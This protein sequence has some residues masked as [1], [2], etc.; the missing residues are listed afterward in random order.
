MPEVLDT[1]VLAAGTRVGEYE[2]THKLGEGGMGVVYAGLHPEIG[3]RVAIKVLA[4]HAAQYPDLIRRFK[5]EARA[6]NKIRHPNIIDIFAFNQLP[7][8]R[9]YFVMEYLDGESLTARLERGPMEFAEMRRLLGQIC[10]ALQ[11]AHQAG[12]VHRD[13]KPDN[14]WVATE[15]LTES[16]IKLLDF[17]IAKLNDLTNASTTQAGVPMGTPHY[18]PPEQGMGRAIDARADIYALGVILYQLFAGVLPFDGATAHEVV[19]KHVTEPPP[20]PSSH[21]P[22]SPPEMEGIILACLEK[23]PA[24]RPP[25]VKELW[26]SIDAAF[27]RAAAAPARPSAVKAV[28]RLPG[29]RTA[30][31]A[32]VLLPPSLQP[33]TTLRGTVGELQA[34][35]DGDGFLARPRRRTGRTIGMVLAGGAAVAA[36]VFFAASAR[37]GAEVAVPAARP[38]SV[39]AMAM[40]AATAPAR[41]PTPAVNP[42]NAPEAPKAP[43]PIAPAAPVAATSPSAPGNRASPPAEAKVSAHRPHADHAHRTEHAPKI[44]EKIGEKIAEAPHEAPPAPTIAPKPNCN[45]NFTLDAQGEKHFKPECF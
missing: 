13:L 24:R 22:I 33:P 4:P 18:M 14:I 23:E 25:S 32:T 15:N 10:S 39:P 30:P 8:G 42:P 31:S 41:A 20:R 37:Q 6:V 27:A 19:L 1:S 38:E 16:R 36:V 26:A 40:P 9:H 2:I 34:L 11:A 3:K 45:P 12:I 43:P 29:A 44:G 28:P 5:E 35:P 7:D 17:G 21:R